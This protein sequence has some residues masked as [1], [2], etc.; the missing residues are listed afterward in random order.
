MTKKDLWKAVKLVN[1]REVRS[2]HCIGEAVLCLYA[3]KVKYQIERSVFTQ[4]I[5]TTSWIGRLIV[6]LVDVYRSFGTTTAL[7]ARM[8]A[9]IMSESR[10]P[11]PRSR[12]M[13]LSCCQ[14]QGH[15]QGGQCGVNGHKD[16][17]GESNADG[18]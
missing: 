5:D 12:R 2:A 9:R 15:R 6:V 18:Y 16:G 4:G 14:G 17:S 11:E 3:R 10:L 1:S 13:A 8:S 7:S